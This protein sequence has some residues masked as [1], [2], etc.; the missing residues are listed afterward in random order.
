MIAKN[1]KLPRRSRVFGTRVAVVDGDREFLNAIAT[2]LRAE[3]LRV[4]TYRSASEAYD[5]FRE[6]LP[7]A[8]VLSREMQGLSGMQILETLRRYSDIPILMTST[9]EHDLDEAMAFRLGADDYIRKPLRERALVE[10][11]RAKLRRS[12]IAEPAK[13]HVPPA[14]NRNPIVQFGP[15]RID[16]DRAEITFK[17]VTISTTKGEYQLLNCLMGNP[18]IVRSKEK[19][20]E[21]LPCHARGRSETLIASH[22]K[23]IRAKIR[24]VDPAAD[25]IATHYGL[26]YTM[27]P[28][29]ASLAS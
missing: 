18:E 27:N 23:R 6:K 25:P 3:G 4:D 12:H 8:L 10:R 20:L 9:S 17:G 5:S 28:A 1:D 15:L 19:L 29:M 7:D 21:L 22:V 26:G 11:V 16:N 14:A 24:A 2:L 13:I